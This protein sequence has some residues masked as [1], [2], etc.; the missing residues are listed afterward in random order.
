MIFGA[1]PVLVLLLPIPVYYHYRYLEY[2]YC[3]I[4]AKAAAAAAVTTY[5][6]PKCPASRGCYHLFGHLL[7]PSE[8]VIRSMRGPVAA[9]VRMW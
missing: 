9:D 6:D 5:I 8:A 3:I 2:Y 4:K 1:I 7:P